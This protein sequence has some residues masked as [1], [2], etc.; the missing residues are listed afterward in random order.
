MARKQFPAA[1]QKKTK[2]ES[3]RGGRPLADKALSG[4]HPRLIH[5]F[6]VR[7]VVTPNVGAAAGK[8][9]RPAATASMRPRRPFP[10]DTK[11]EGPAD[12]ST[13]H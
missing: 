10:A 3:P 5:G 1:R 4:A 7:L 12:D 9:V 8:S 13:F 2:K 6:L 11:H